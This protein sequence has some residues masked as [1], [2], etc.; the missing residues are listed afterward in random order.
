[1]IPQDPTENPIAQSDAVTPEPRRSAARTI[2]RNTIF[3]LG[4]QFALKVASFIFQV[5]VIRQLG[6]EEFGQYSIVTAWV[7]L[8]SVIGDLG[9]N[10]YLAREI[11]RNP[12]RIKDLFWNTV[13][14]RLV[15]ALVALIVTA[16]AAYVYGYNTEIIVAT[17]IFTSSYFFQALLAP[18]N[19]V[20]TGNERL[21]LTSILSVITQVLFMVF[22]GLFLSLG[23]NFTWLAVASTLNIPIVL[24]IAYRMVKKH[25]F[26][27]P[28]FHITPATWISLIRLGLPF[29]F[30]QL[31]LS[32]SFRVDTIILS[33][34]V[35]DLEVGWYNVAY[36]L[37]FNILS[38]VT[39]FS[40]AILP[41]LAREHAIDPDSV[42]PWYYNSTRIMIFLGLPTA[43]GITVL[44]FKLVGF[45]YQP[46]IAPAAIPLM[47]LIWDIPFSMYQAFC[48][49]L[50]QSMKLEVDAARIFGSLG[51]L[52]LALN[53]ILIPPLGI[54]GSSFATVIT[55]CTGSIQYYILLRRKLGSGIRFKSV[56]RI[57]AAVVLM[58]AILYLAYDLHLFILIA[59]GGLSYLV[60]V[61]FSGAFTSE[62][63]GQ[64][65]RITRRLIPVRTT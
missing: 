13:L 54:L 21:D 35:S 36:G 16:V 55:D 43:A 30:M 40:T 46:E 19:S 26:P 39:S 41:T 1:M 28:K 10:Q 32:F 53:L 61:W 48:G 51:V 59:L 18:I 9:V 4:A 31:A 14:I 6:G 5:L 64:L 50:T 23:L 65:L 17:I 58:S 60:I 25:N 34:Q 29:A 52:N 2:A 49:N 15:L 57:I 20:L 11:A 33:G 27:P 38:I 62:E 12:N 37:I 45:L 7:G 44:A 3:G 47:I 63:R 22:A 24:V 8:F 42:K 56:L